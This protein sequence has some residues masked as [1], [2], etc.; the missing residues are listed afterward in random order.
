[1]AVDGT[2]GASLRC[3]RRSLQ[4]TDGHNT[5]IVTGGSQG[6]GAGVVN[7]FL[8]RGYNVV[9]NSLNV[10][11]SGAFAPSATLALVDGDIAQSTTAAKI[12]DIAIRQFG[13]IDVVV[14]N[15]GTF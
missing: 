4:V 6:I 1:M 11:K 10:T 14:N 5:V 12:A 8:K 3:P 9:A 13:S 15:A 2:S 7:A